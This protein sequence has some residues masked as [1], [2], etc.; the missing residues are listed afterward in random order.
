MHSRGRSAAAKCSFVSLLEHLAELT[1][2]ETARPWLHQYSLWNCGAQ[3]KLHSQS[4]PAQHWS[5]DPHSWPRASV[6]SPSAAPLCRGQTSC[7]VTQRL[8]KQTCILLEKS[9]GMNQGSFSQGL[10]A[11]GQV[12][13]TKLSYYRKKSPSVEFLQP[14]QQPQKTPEKCQEDF[15]PTT[16][17]Y[18]VKHDFL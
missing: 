15:E 16:L 17:K 1:A 7:A 13:N 12:P 6:P 9:Q 3:P 11:V 5:F 4:I 8:Q 10:S 18:K 14:Y 2:A